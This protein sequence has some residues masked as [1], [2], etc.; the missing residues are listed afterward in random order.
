MLS[1]VSLPK[2]QR[3]ERYFENI[4]LFSLQSNNPL[5][6]KVLQFHI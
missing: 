4:K 1:L 5:S 2:D 6:F 3:L